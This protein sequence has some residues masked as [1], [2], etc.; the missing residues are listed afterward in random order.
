MSEAFMRVFLLGL[1]LSCAPWAQASHLSEAEVSDMERACE[2]LRQEKLK[3]EKT[4]VLQQCLNEGGDQASCEQRAAA[5]GE[6]STGAIRRLGKYY[7]LPECIEAY[8]ARRHYRI[9][10]GR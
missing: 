5:Y 2:T 8:D 3:P 7:D 6:R 9:N 4:A 1:C 10:P